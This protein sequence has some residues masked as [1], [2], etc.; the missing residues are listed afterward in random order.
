MRSDG[1]RCLGGVMADK[2]TLVN[3]EGRQ[4]DLKAASENMRRHIPDLMENAKMIAKIRR[5]AFL[6]HVDEG[7]TKAQALELCKSLSL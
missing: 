1:R 5:A 3:L 2:P 6:A 7:F 4:D